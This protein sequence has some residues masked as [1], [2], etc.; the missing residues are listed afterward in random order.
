MRPSL[1]LL[2]VLACDGETSRTAAPPTPAPVPATPAPPP[3]PTP[4]PEE[5]RGHM[6]A[7]F[8]RASDAAVALLRGELS[9]ARVALTQLAT[10][11]PPA[12]WPLEKHEAVTAMQ[13]AA[14]RGAAAETLKP[15][16]EALGDVLVACGSCHAT[17]SGG[18]LYPPDDLT[19]STDD[20]RDHMQRHLWAMDRLW[21]GMVQPR[22][23]SWT[24]GL[25]VL[26]FDPPI[27]DPEW[28]ETDQAALRRLHD[29]STA[30]G[31]SHGT[32][33]GRL[34]AECGACHDRHDV[35]LSAE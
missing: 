28:D 27:T 4:H 26:A 14:R 25:Q 22:E 16:A 33:Y 7:H 34:L 17:A 10:D 12:G 2:T 20:V 19:L 32:H 21:E 5:V 13:E 24:M 15:V 1:L 35:E 31:L 29:L 6:H 18:P 23:L 30:T 9:D 8:A 11:R 3:L